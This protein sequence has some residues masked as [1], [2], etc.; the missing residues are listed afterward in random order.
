M[1]ATR[2]P[3]G[4]PGAEVLRA[5]LLDPRG[6]WAPLTETLLHFAA[7][8]DH[9]ACTIGPALAAGTWVVSDRFYDSTMAYQ[10]YGQLADRAAIAQLTTLIG[11]RPDLTLILDVS[12]AT[13]RTR[14]IARGRS[15][16]RYEREGAAF[17][18]RVRAG[19]RAIAAAEPDR[20]VLVPAD[21][22]A[23]EVHEAIMAAV[24]QRLS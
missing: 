15:P 9:I 2:E 13:A 7:R 5:L 4:S 24:G 16:D 18:E 10:G 8:A 6:D 21:G 3:G 11:L 1:L 14:M 23:Q 19:Y 12:E 22:A 20:C 17:H